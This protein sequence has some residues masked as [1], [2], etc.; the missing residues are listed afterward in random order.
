MTNTKRA[1][2][3]LIALLVTMAIPAVGCGG[4][5]QYVV[6]GNQQ[7][8]LQTNLK[9]DTRRHQINSVLYQNFD[10]VGMLPVCSPVTIDSVGSGSIRFRTQD[11][12]SYT[13]VRSNHSRIP[14]E[15]HVQ[16]YFGAGCPD[17]ASMSAADQSG[18]RD[19]AVYEG[20]SK[21]GVLIALGY[22]PEH[23]T[24][25]LDGDVWKYW[26]NRYDTFEV[27]FVNGLVS[28]IRD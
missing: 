21:A 19:G 23:Q 1:R 27:Y 15:E 8:Y 17:V 7:L 10:G 3:T 13:Y 9:V 22:P 25:S 20:M 4:G 14:I 12:Q 18:I 26:K 2:G 28:G 11:G 5:Q 24:P 16:H 6:E